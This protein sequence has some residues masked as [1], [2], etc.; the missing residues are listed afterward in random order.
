M[1]MVRP[2]LRNFGLIR[3]AESDI[4]IHLQHKETMKESLFSLS[5]PLLPHLTDRLS[6]QAAQGFTL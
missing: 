3:F 5:H 4:I 2:E 1:K 6:L